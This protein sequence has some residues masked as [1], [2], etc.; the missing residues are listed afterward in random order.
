MFPRSILKLFKD[1]ADWLSQRGDH[2]TLWFFLGNKKTFKWINV[3]KWKFIYVSVSLH[4]LFSCHALHPY[5]IQHCD[6]FTGIWWEYDGLV[7]HSRL[8]SLRDDA[9]RTDPWDLLSVKGLGSMQTLGWFPFWKC[10]ELLGICRETHG[11][12]NGQGPR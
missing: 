3:I 11:T 9:N 1:S 5:G 12:R 7:L 6:D 4:I 2:S 8:E 10:H